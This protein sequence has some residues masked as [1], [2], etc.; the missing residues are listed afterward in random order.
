MNGNGNMHNN[1]VE[2]YINN[3]RINLNAPGNQGRYTRSH[4]FQTLEEWDAIFNHS[5]G[6][7]NDIAFGVMEDGEY[8]YDQYEDRCERARR[9][10]YDHSEECS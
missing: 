7:D 2:N 5:S 8:D 9:E 3:N 6:I 10:H 4:H 1:Q